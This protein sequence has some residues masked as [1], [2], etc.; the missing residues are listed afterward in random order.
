MAFNESQA[1]KVMPSLT[2]Q[3]TNVIEGPS[4]TPPDLD[5][6]LYR[7]ILLPNGLRC[8]LIEDVLATPATL[9]DDDDDE[10]DSTSSGE[11]K[12]HDHDESDDEDDS[13]SDED[14]EEE[15]G[16]RDAAVCIVVGVG[17]MYD[18]PDCQGLAHFLEHLLFM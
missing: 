3:D 14:D 7:Q 18:P 16:L 11:A 4:L 10:S 12:K 9:E 1:T 13:G 6:K 2:L 8:V 5:K 15:S 17:S